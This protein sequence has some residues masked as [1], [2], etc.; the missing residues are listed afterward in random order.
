MTLDLFAADEEAVVD[1]ASMDRQAEREA[2]ADH[3]VLALLDRRAKA[4]SAVARVR[5][6]AH[7]ARG[8]TVSETVDGI[9]VALVATGAWS[10]TGPDRRIRIL[11]DQAAALHAIVALLGGGEP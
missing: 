9:R 2:E 11:P 1:F 5:E 4:A 7:G 10:V 6:A 3:A 8:R